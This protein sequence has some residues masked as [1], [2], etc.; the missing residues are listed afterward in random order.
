[1][2]RNLKTVILVKRAIDWRVTGEFA[3]YSIILKTIMDESKFDMSKVIFAITFS[4]NQV[5]SDAEL[6]AF[7][8][9]FWQ[10]AGFEADG[11]AK[12]Y[13]RFVRHG[14]DSKHEDILQKVLDLMPELKT[15]E[16]INV[17]INKDFKRKLKANAQK[18][19]SAGVLEIDTGYSCFKNGQYVY[20]CNQ[21][22][23]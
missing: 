23:G 21:E 17:D 22:G 4:D 5:V 14:R 10:S 2:G 15:I 18:S 16:N 1:M 13:G 6:N 11:I 20:R 8:D 7:V 12:P 19:K 3:W 9:K